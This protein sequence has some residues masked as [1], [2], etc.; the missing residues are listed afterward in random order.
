MFTLFGKS[1]KFNVLK[2]RKEVIGMDF[3]EENILLDVVV[4]SQS[5]L[6][7]SVARYAEKLGFVKDVEKVYEAFV[8]RESEYST[9]LQDGFAIPHAK[10]PYVLAPTVLFIRLEN[11]LEWET[12]D[13]SRVKNI[14]A[15]LVPKED[16]GTLHL[17]MLSRLATAL[18]ED[19]FISQVQKNT[20][21]DQLVTVIK[22]EMIGE[23]TL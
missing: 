8:E 13:E 14:F 6:F 7:K 20:N 1:I 11:E 17:E 16:E 18:M 21:K 5:E 15:L 4:A 3:T 9:G 23:S 12:F 19:E 10:S 22:N 2:Q